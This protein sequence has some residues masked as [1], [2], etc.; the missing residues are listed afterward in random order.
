MIIR[1]LINE[2]LSRGIY[3]R[4]SIS[5]LDGSGKTYMMSPLV[6][7]YE[8][9]KTNWVTPYLTPLRFMKHYRL[10]DR[11]PIIDRWVYTSLTKPD[12]DYL[13]VNKAIEL[14]DKYFDDTVY[15][16]YL[17]DRYRSIKPNEP[18]YVDKNRSEIL[19]RFNII[20]N[21]MINHKMPVILVMPDG[22]KLYNL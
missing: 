2:L 4:A 14:L 11:N 12:F 5:G 6:G 3:K 13:S 21:T 16:I 22:V 8:Y 20:S 17:H 15:V 10:F 18:D 19:K 7:E 1:D 9:F